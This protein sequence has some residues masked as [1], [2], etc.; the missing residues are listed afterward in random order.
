MRWTS[1]NQP[2]FVFS[3]PVDSFRTIYA[4]SDTHVIIWTKGETHVCDQYW[5]VLM[6]LPYTAETKNSE[7]GLSLLLLR[8]KSSTEPYRIFHPTR[9]Q[10]TTTTYPDKGIDLNFN[11]V[12]NQNELWVTGMENNV[13]MI[14]SYRYDG[15]LQLTS[16]KAIAKG[17]VR[18]LPFASYWVSK[19][20]QGELYYLGPEYEFRD[21]FAFQK[22]TL[23]SDNVHFVASDKQNKT[24]RFYQL[25]AEKYIEIPFSDLDSAMEY[26][27]SSIIQIWKNNKCGLYF[28]NVKKILPP[29]YTQVVGPYNESMHLITCDGN[30]VSTL[31]GEII[32]NNSF[33][34]C[35]FPEGKYLLSQ[36]QDGTWW[37]CNNQPNSENY[38][39]KKQLPENIKKWIGFA[40]VEDWHKF[41]DHSGM[42]GI[43]NVKTDEWILQPKFKDVRAAYA[44]N[45]LCF[46]YSQGSYWGVCDSTGKI[47]IADTFDS[48]DLQ[49]AY[50]SG[51]PYFTARKNGQYSLYNINGKALLPSSYP[52]IEGGNF[53]LVLVTQY[54]NDKQTPLTGLYDVSKG[55]WLYPLSKVEYSFTEDPQGKKV[56]YVEQNGKRIKVIYP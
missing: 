30:L 28:P 41:M 7:L 25:T 43:Y 52:E 2:E 54:A 21:T 11:S 53:P 40:G 31:T 50:P 47:I 55:K 10:L 45:H 51:T 18:P 32:F 12:E 39:I 6:T 22:L 13:H 3:E 38:L 16:K 19:E 23:M 44:G 33:K 35:E 48:I 56:I 20:H 24:T 5:N 49:E 9:C 4:N 1:R 36:H 17:N 15:T 37:I 29:V 14:Y 34:R 27:N 46:F 26:G 8:P 42:V